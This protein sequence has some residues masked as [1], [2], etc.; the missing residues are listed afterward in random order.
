MPAVNYI[1][2]ELEF[3][4]AVTEANF[5]WSNTYMPPTFPLLRMSPKELRLKEDK[6]RSYTDFP[7]YFQNPGIKTNFHDLA[8]KD[9]RTDVKRQVEALATRAKLRVHT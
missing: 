2:N 3:S 5:V 7:A 9:I 8:G 1:S 6:E 4:G